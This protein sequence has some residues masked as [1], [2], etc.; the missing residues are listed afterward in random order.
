MNSIISTPNMK[1]FVSGANQ[2]MHKRQQRIMEDLGNGFPIRKTM[3][4]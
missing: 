1:F 4:I 3:K 2:N